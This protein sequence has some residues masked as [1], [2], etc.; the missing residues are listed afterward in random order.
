MFKIKIEKEFNPKMDEKWFV[1]YDS[2][3]DKPTFTDKEDE[4]G[5]FVPTIEDDNSLYGNLM[6]L[7]DRF[8]YKGTPIIVNE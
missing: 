1:G 8:G 3:N 7:Y 4:A 5:I 2:V 6:A